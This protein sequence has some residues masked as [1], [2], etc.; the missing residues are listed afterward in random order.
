MGRASPSPGRVSFAG[1]A[2]G[3]AAL[4]TCILLSGSTGA[5]AQAADDAPTAQAAPPQAPASD[6]SCV[7]HLIATTAGN[8]AVGL[9]IAGVGDIDG[10]G[11]GDF[12]IG[13]AS[14]GVDCPT[15]SI[16]LCG[17]AGRPAWCA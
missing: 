7:L 5:L 13:N 3:T 12:A 17:G 14:D 9:S 1:R 2:A 10:D 6:P 16:T 4:H 8:Q 15:G 11:A